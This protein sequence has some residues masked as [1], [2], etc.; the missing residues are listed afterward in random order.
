MQQGLEPQTCTGTFKWVQ[1]TW[2]WPGPTDVV[3]KWKQVLLAYCSCEKHLSHK[4]IIISLA[5]FCSWQHQHYVKLYHNL[6]LGIYHLNQN[7]AHH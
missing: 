7:G 6:Q 4:Y 1:D 2:I 5:S 3:Q